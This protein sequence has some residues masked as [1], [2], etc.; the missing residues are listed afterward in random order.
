MQTSASRNTIIEYSEFF[1]P[2][3]LSSAMDTPGAKITFAPDCIDN[4]LVLSF[5]P[6]STTIMSESIRRNF[7]ILEIVSDISSSSLRAG[8]TKLTFGFSLIIFLVKLFASS[9]I[10]ERL[11]LRVLKAG[12][13]VSHQNF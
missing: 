3:F 7:L 5:D 13:V 6:L 10:I 2:I 1:D 9:F 11:N 12:K 8:M 4:D